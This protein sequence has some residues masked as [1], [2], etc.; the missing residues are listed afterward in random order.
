MLQFGL[1]KKC[2][3]T[4][5]S[6]KPAALTPPARR[7]FD[8][9][10]HAARSFCIGEAVRCLNSIRIPD[11]EA[12]KNLIA[13]AFKRRT[14]DANAFG[15]FLAE[16]PDN[17]IN[18]SQLVA[19]VDTYKTLLPAT[20][21]EGFYQ[22]FLACSVL[23]SELLKKTN[24]QQKELVLCTILAR[25]C[26][27]AQFETECQ[28]PEN[29]QE[30]NKIP[31]NILFGIDQPTFDKLLAEPNEPSAVRQRACQVVSLL[32]EISPRKLLTEE[33]LVLT[34]YSCL[35]RPKI[36]AKEFLALI[37]TIC[38]EKIEP[39]DL[40]C[41]ALN[42]LAWLS[43][44]YAEQVKTCLTQVNNEEQAG[45]ATQKVITHFFSTVEPEPRP[46]RPRRRTSSF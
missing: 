10:N 19:L 21:S 2:M 13:S 8:H 29:K 1:L 34:S 25:R 41:T 36:N 16:L 4:A 45:S 12:G 40:T 5:P 28:T 35:D 44:R 30:I 26:R 15:K 6:T 22:N 39:K 33:R 42:M 9:V 18:M 23:P 46:Q 37:T 3:Q 27:L 31:K 17:A 14:Q 7:E 20:A 38:Q 11:Q 43:I 24:S 32:A